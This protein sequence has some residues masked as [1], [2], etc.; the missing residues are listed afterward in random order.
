MFNIPPLRIVEGFL[1]T[2]LTLT[3]IR[4]LRTKLH[5]PI[6][7]PELT[8]IPGMLATVVDSRQPVKDVSRILNKAKPTLIVLYDAIAGDKKLMD[9]SDMID[10]YKE[11]PERAGNSFLRSSLI[12]SRHVR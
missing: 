11:R 10:L 9:I 4:A 2:G 8:V 6:L 7:P 3:E 1:N 5:S 12:I